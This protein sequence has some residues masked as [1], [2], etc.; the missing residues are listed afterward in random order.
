[1]RRFFKFTGTTSHSPSIARGRISSSRRI[2]VYSA[3]SASDHPG[4]HRTSGHVAERLDARRLMRLAPIHIPAE[5]VGSTC[6]SEW[7]TITG[8]QTSGNGRIDSNNLSST[9]SQ[10]NLEDE[11]GSKRPQRHAAQL[12]REVLQKIV[13]YA[14]ASVALGLIQVVR[15]PG[16]VSAIDIVATVA[17]GFGVL[18]LPV[19]FVFGASYVQRQIPLTSTDARRR[20]WRALLLYSVAVLVG[21]VVVTFIPQTGTSIGWIVSVGTML[22]YGFYVVVLLALAGTVVSSVALLGLRIQ[23]RLAP[24]SGTRK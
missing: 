7:S 12:R 20:R 14:S 6:R 17:V 23:H 3:H 8:T 18:L 11:T 15:F 24:Q 4:T 13:L 16:H 21:C 22:A 5:R 1:M 9:E 2:D 19:L 10:L